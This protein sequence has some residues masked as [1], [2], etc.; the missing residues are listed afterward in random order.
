MRHTE[1]LEGRTNLNLNAGEL[2]STGVTVFDRGIGNGPQSN[3]LSLGL[4]TD[5]DSLCSGVS[6]DLDT[7]GVGLGLGDSGVAVSISLSLKRSA[8]Q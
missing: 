1:R 7:L 5:P 2:S 6:F 4:G 3:R 8:R